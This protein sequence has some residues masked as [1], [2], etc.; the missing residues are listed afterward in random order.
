M[1]VCLVVVQLMINKPWSPLLGIG[2]HSKYEV[3]IALGVPIVIKLTKGCGILGK[4]S[5]WDK[6]VRLLGTD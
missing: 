2:K 1:R 4:E 5:I 6:S 3:Q